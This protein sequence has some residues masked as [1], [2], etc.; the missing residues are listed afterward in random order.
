MVL[1]LVLDD[2]ESKGCGDGLRGG[3]EVDRQQGL[4]RDQDG[5]GEERLGSPSGSQVC[6]VESNSVVI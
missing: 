5:G 4:W 2:S 6:L 1:V 3:A